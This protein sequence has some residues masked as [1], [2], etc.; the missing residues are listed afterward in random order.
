MK[1]SHL[2]LY[3]LIANLAFSLY[4]QVK[5]HRA[6]HLVNVVNEQGKNV[7]SSIKL[8]IFSSILNLS[9]QNNRGIFPTNEG[10]TLFLEAGAAILPGWGI[11]VIKQLRQFSWLKAGKDAVPLNSCSTW[12]LFPATSTACIAAEFI[13]QL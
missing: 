4:P 12:E 10:A 1:F 2:L 13:K 9:F 6:C 3:Y 5:S 11:E 8:D 7:P